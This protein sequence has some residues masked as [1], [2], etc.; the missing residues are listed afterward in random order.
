MSIG[1]RVTEFCDRF[2]LQSPVM[3]APMAGVTPPELSIAVIN[4]GGMGSC[5]VL[6]LTPDEIARWSATVRRRSANR[7]QLNT[8]V[9][10]PEPVRS[11]DKEQA[12]A[13]F[14]GEWGPAVAKDAGDAARIDFD[15]Q[16]EAMLAARPAAISSVMGLFSPDYVERLQ[17]SKIAWFA[18]VSTV[19]E[20]RLA[21]AAGADAIIAQ[22]MEAGGHR[23]SFDACAAE[24]NLVG[25]TSLIPIVV[26]AVSVPVIATGGIA[27]GRGAAA[28]LS[29]GASAVQIGSG[30]LRSPEAGINHA[31]A[32][33]LGRTLPEETA[34]TRVF[35]GRAG[36]AL[37]NRFVR[38]SAEG[39]APDAAPYPVQRGLTAAM[40]ADAA[41][42]A[43]IERMQ[44]WAGQSSS[45]ARNEPA[46][47]IVARVWSEARAI[48][49]SVLER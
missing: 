22:G 39:D 5:G 25:L 27:D 29:L 19:S 12:M 40:R 11:H 15:A 36:R 41:S 33:A 45:L 32:E 38:R 10:D 2:D 30:F 6:L 16:C 44:A 34:V 7:F 31:W 28:A 24:R 37:R 43:D 9:P 4:A 17:R 35:T 3:L 49:G 21:E 48:L 8:W 26:D 14:L 20:A 42:S 13:A 18:V 1:E 46:G 23:A 47:T